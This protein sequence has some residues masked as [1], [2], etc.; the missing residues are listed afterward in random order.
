M[1]TDAAALGAALQATWC[2][3][4]PSTSLED[5]CARLVRLDERSRTNPEPNR[6]AAY[7]QAYARYCQALENHYS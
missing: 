5:L 6:V 2:E 7:G 3:R 4:Y 1:A